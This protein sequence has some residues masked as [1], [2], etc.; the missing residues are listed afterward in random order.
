MR[1]GD[2]M[3]STSKIAHVRF[4]GASVDTLDGASVDVCNELRSFLDS[5]I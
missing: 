4:D 2:V 1:C 3:V 5:S